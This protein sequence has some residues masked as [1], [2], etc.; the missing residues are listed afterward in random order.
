[1][2][3]KKSLRESSDDPLLN[4]LDELY[5]PYA[6]MHHARYHDPAIPYHIV[7]RA[8]QG[9]A[10]LTPTVELN[11]LIA[12]VIG[13]AQTV[14]TSITVYGL[15]FLSNHAH[16]MI[17]GLAH[18]IPAFIGYVKKEI[19]RRLGPEIDWHDTMWSAGY[20]STALPTRESH[21]TCLEYILSQGTKE[22]LVDRPEQWPGLHIA[23]NLLLREPL[24]GSWLNGTRYA[25]ALW[26]E[27]QKPKS[28]Q[29]TIDKS[30]YTESYQIQ[31]TVLPAW[32][33]LS[34]AE[35]GAKVAKMV[36]KIVEKARISRAGKPSLSVENIL[37]V[38]R[39]V[40]WSMP[41]IP[42][43]QERRRMIVWAD[44]KAPETLA[45]RQ[46][47]AAFQEAFRAAADDYLAGNANA[48]FPAG[49]FRP[50]LFASRLRSV[51]TSASRAA[52]A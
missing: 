24:I 15:A 9:L 23:K 12:G 18:E 42:W 30:K 33:E 21:E 4:E 28:K 32:A 25:K 43:F 31:T 13:R 11:A 48:L 8:F 22:H 14:Y 46:K 40:R 44:P 1:M 37:K 2:A 27:R 26:K 36:A 3:K 20:V 19:S 50:S 51:D 41:K 29:R 39:S 45:Y 49:S 35:R 6:S 52:A 10:L 47:Y 7:L 34:E 17:Q 16:L 5:G 38:P